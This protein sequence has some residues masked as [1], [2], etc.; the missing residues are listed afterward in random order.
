MLSHLTV[1]LALIVREQPQMVDWFI[2]YYKPLLKKF[3]VVV[4]DSEGGE[5]LK[6][7]ASQYIKELLPLDKARKLVIS[8][9]QT[10]F[11]ANV[12]I[13]TQLPIKYIYSALRLLQ[14][15]KADA[16]A[17]DYK[18]PQGHLAFGTSF[19]RTSTLQKLYDWQMGGRFCECIHMWR[20]THQNK[21]KLETLPFYAR[22]IK[23]DQSHN[24]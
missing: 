19:W 17:I 3:D 21:F 2:N 11:T 15:N 4:V 5:S 18:P 1:S 7:Y 12:D 20:R 14:Q 6:Q 10:P 9:T 13:D 23:N 16:V 24:L 8:K 22:H